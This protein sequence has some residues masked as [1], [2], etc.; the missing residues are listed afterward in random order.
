MHAE[1]ANGG[2][3]GQSKSPVSGSHSPSAPSATTQVS[4]PTLTTHG[5]AI[6][7][8][9]GKPYS[10]CIPSRSKTLNRGSIYNRSSRSP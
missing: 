9:R 2:D 10:T 3:N 5:A 8:G 7:C 1:D 4:P 6:N